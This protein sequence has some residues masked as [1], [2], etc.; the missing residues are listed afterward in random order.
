LC[1]ARNRA[2]YAFKHSVHGDS[3]QRMY[4]LEDMLKSVK[5]AQR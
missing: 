4:R 1:A 5:K 2:Q 3:L